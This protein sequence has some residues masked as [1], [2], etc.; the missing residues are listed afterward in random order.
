MSCVMQ[1][2]SAFLCVGGECFYNIIMAKKLAKLHCLGQNKIESYFSRIGVNAM[3]KNVALYNEMIAFFAGDAR[4]CQHFI[5][6]ASLAKQLAESE[7]ADA[8][9]T[10]L[11]EAAGFVHDCGIKPGTGK[12]QEQEGPAVARELLQKVGYAPEKIERICYLVGH[13][14]TYNMIDGLD[15]QLLVEADFIVNFYEDGTPK[16][17]IAKT[18]ERIF[19]TE[20]GTKLAKTMFGL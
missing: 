19:K 17:N 3:N 15:Y 14:H 4:R 7:G 9:L 16:E 18:V 6:V 13:H 8:E 12:I 10:E 5:K 20:S 11:V 2:K 1:A